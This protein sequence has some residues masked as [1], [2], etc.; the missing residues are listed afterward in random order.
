M[1]YDVKKRIDPI[2][3]FVDPDKM[4][5]IGSDTQRSIS[6]YALSRWACYLIAMNGDPTKAEIAAA[7]AYFAI[8]TRRMEIED[9]HAE[10]A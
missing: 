5:A 3:H 7:Q 4:V 2:N 9:N 10:L 8:Q 1:L 6:D